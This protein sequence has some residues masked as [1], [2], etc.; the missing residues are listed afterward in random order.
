MKK[1]AIL[2]ITLIS[3]LQLMAE[4][5]YDIT[6]RESLPIDSASTFRNYMLVNTDQQQEFINWR[7]D[8]VLGTQADQTGWS[9]FEN[10]RVLEAY[11]RTPREYFCR[12]FNQSRAYAHAALPIGYGQTI[13]GIFAVGNMTDWLNP[14]PEDKILEIGTGSGYQ[15]AVL[16]QLSVHVY[17]IEIVEE[18]AT[19]THRIYESL[20]DDYPEFSNI[21]YKIDD[22]YYGWE[23]YAPF[24][25]IIVTCGIDHIPPA[26]LSQLKDG[27]QML[28]P[29]G[30]PSGQTILSVTK[31]IDED[32]NIL[33]DRED[34]YG[35]RMPTSMTTFVP[36]TSKEGTHFRNN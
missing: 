14:D 9:G 4:E 33:T 25:K 20:K 13:S 1:T 8:S 35:G 21:T 30:P 12:S 19:E 26:L 28:I 18:L 32:G 6:Q 27:G 5:P 34:I 11:L 17:S 24:D 16:S 23:E 10:Q 22:G 3:I 29:I 15:S 36:F 31:R 2:I 7:Y